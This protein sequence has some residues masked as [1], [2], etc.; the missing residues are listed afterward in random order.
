MEWVKKIIFYFILFFFTR[1]GVSEKILVFVAPHQHYPCYE[2]IEELINIDNDVSCARGS[3]GK[4][5][6]SGRCSTA[7]QRVPGRQSITSRIRWNKQVNIVVMECFYRSRPFNE[8]GFPVMLREWKEHGMFE[9][10]KQRICDQVINKEEWM[11][12]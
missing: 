1:D 9:S 11:V 10:T 8:N 5:A 3:N 2:C 12:K 6:S 4:G 7:Q